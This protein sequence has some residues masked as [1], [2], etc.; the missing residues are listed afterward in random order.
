MYI[1]TDPW[2]FLKSNWLKDE[3]IEFFS[4]ERDNIH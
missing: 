3:I 4:K 2:S 1:V